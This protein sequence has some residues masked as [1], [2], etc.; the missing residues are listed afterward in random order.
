MSARDG[1]AAPSVVVTTSAS[2]VPAART[3]STG[4]PAALSRA[5]QLERLAQLVRPRPGGRI[6]EGDHEIGLGGRRQTALD[7]GP[8]FEIVGERDRAEIAAQ[9]RAHLG[10]RRQHRGDA[11]LDSDVEVAPR[12]IAR[13]HRLEHRRRHGEHAGIAARHDGD[14]A[15]GSG[16]RQ[17][18]P[19]AIELDAIVRSVAALVVAR[20]ERGRDRGRSPRGRWH[21]PARPALPASSTRPCRAPCRP[22]RASRSQPPA[23]ARDQHHGEIGAGRLA[24]LGERQ[25]ALVLHG[26]ALDIDARV[27][28]GPPPRR[29]AAPCRD[30]GRLS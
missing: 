2:A 23:L 9:R 16:K 3:N 14:L 25:D 12:R 27:T 30:C 5:Q 19:R 10:R 15:A 8:G 7:R 11:G 6:V 13:L 24:A 29:R 17:R 4:V 1:S 20:A 28:A 21:A 26:A 18:K 22:P